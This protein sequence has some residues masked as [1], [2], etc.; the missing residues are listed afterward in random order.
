MD[1]FS[2]FNGGVASGDIT[3]ANNS[4]MRELA[5]ILIQNRDEFVFLLTE[6]GLTASAEMTDGQLINLF[7]NNVGTNRE[8]MLG[9]SFLV[10]ALNKKSGADGEEEINDTL[11]KSG[12]YTMHSYFNGSS[13]FNNYSNAGG[14]ASIVAE[15]AKFGNRLAEGAQKRKFGASDALMRKMDAQAEMNKQAVELR[16]SQIADAQK[17]NA[18]RQKTTRTALIAGGVIALVAVIGGLFYVFK[19]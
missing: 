17:Q 19:K 15:G 2:Q 14:V 10:A 9:A 4:L 18:Q 5:K 8:L 13:Y 16:K 3:S 12:F 11:V 6:S 7:V 1:F